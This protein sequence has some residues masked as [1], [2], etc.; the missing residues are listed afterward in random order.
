MVREAERNVQ[1]LPM[2]SSI[3]QRWGKVFSLPRSRSLISDP[4][5]RALTLV[6]ALG[7]AVLAMVS[8]EMLQAAP[9]RVGY[10]AGLLGSGTGAWWDYPAVVLTLPRTLVVLPFFTTV[11]MVLV[12][13]GVGVGMAVGLLLIGR[14]LRVRSPESLEV[15]GPASVAGVTPALIGLLTLGACCSTAAAAAAGVASVDQ[16]PGGS[17]ALLLGEAWYLPVVQLVVV[18][19]ALLAQE[20]LLAFYGLQGGRSGPTAP[21]TLSTSADGP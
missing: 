9:G 1:G 21:G 3:A 10:S 7:Y 8:G 20:Q 4:R 2:R 19:L 17:N 18:G 16:V 13:L 15:L 14:F 12:S 11:A 6:V 5:G